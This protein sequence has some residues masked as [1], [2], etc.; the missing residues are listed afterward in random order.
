[1]NDIRKM[2]F[3]FWG[4]GADFMGGKLSFF[5]RCLSV[6]EG[7]YYGLGFGSVFCFCVFCDLSD[8]DVTIQDGTC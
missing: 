2:F 7:V 8:N 6:L 1:M 5:F 3:F 4:G